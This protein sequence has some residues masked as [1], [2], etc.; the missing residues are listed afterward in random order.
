MWKK[1][2]RA[3]RTTYE[4]RDFT[5]KV[6]FARVESALRGAAPQFGQ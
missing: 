2:A 3:R 5:V 6:S 1:M 4:R